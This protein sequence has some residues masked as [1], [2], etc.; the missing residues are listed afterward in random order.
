V[1]AHPGHELRVYHWLE[2]AHPLVFV[3]TDGSGHTQHSRLAKTSALL[4][5]AGAMPGLIYGRMPDRELYRAILA[6]DADLFIAL[7]EE[8]ASTLDSEGVDYIVGDAVEGVN[9]GHDVCRLL[10]NAALLRIGTTRGRRL[11]NLEFPVEGAP[12][13]CPLEDKGDAILLELAED[14][15]Q[16]KLDAA[17]SYS[18]IAIDMTRLIAN[19]EPE[20]FRTECLRP[21][22]YGLDIG[23]R[24]Q[25]PAIYEG[26]GEKQVAAGFYRE[27]IRFREHLAPLA[28]RLGL[29]MARHEG[30]QALGVKT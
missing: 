13:D 2:R 5:R 10:I 8:I 20:A 9:P 23:H 4:D 14:A 1:I 17:R 7:C 29:V 27:V 12:S 30:A 6:G 3:L 15:Y 22:R 25:H 16:R 21:V 19:H 24:F 28:E 18:E 26:Y 11:R